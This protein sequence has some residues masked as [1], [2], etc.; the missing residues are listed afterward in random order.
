MTKVKAPT[1]HKDYFLPPIFP[2]NPENHDDN[3]EEDDD[4]DEDQIYLDYHYDTK[5]NYR[6]PNDL[7]TPKPDI[8]Q[9]ELLPFGGNI[10]VHSAKDDLP[11]FL[12]EPENTYAI[13]NKP[14]ILKC[15]AANTLEVS[16]KI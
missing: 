9:S 4:I 3:E 14:A 2:L 10:P 12:L 5:S 1:E 7:S 16:N 6:D 8:G 11:F 15:K 13:K